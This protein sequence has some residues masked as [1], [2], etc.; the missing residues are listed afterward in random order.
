MGGLGRLLFVA[1]AVGAA[2][3]RGSGRG[4]GWPRQSTPAAGGGGG[5][6]CLPSVGLRASFHSACLDVWVLV[7]ITFPSTIGWRQAGAECVAHL[8]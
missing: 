7:A 2:D 8:T 3:G 5:G 4:K 1:L 6:A